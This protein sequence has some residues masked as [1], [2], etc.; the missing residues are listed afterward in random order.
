MPF[1]SG[2]SD[3]RGGTPLFLTTATRDSDGA[4]FLVGVN[5]W[6]TV[7]EGQFVQ[8]CNTHIQFLGVLTA[9]MFPSVGSILRLG[10]GSYFK[11]TSKSKNVGFGMKYPGT[12]VD[13]YS[14]K[15]TRIGQTQMFNEYFPYTATS[16]IYKS[17]V[18]QNWAPTSYAIQRNTVDESNNFDIV[19]YDSFIS[20]LQDTNS[21]IRS[22]TPTGIFYWSGE[23]PPPS[24]WAYQY[25]VASNASGGALSAQAKQDLLDFWGPNT[26]NPNLKN[27]ILPPD[28]T[29]DTSG[30][31]IPNADY[32]SLNQNDNTDFIKT[33]TLISVSDLGILNLYSP[34]FGQMLNFHN[35]LWST[36]FL[37]NWDNQLKKLFGS[38]EEQIIALLAIYADIPLNAST[39]TIILGNIDSGVSSA[40]V[41]K[42]YITLDCG[43]IDIPRVWGNFLDFEPYTT[44]SIYLPFISTVELSANEIVGKNLHLQYKIDVLTGA[45]VAQ[46]K[47]SDEKKEN[48]IL[49][50]SGNCGIQLPWSSANYNQLVSN[51]INALA[52]IGT[53]TLTGGLAPVLNAE[54][55]TAGAGELASMGSGTVKNVFS[56]ASPRF[57]R[58]GSFNTNN[59]VLCDKI[60]H[61]LITRP[62]QSLAQ[63]Y[64][65]FNGFPS[66]VMSKIGAL[67]GFTIIDKINLQGVSATAEEQE[68]IVNILKTGVIIN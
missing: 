35:Y 44:I 17:G 34:T 33:D 57:S 29:L 23:T 21:V 38:P 26:N 32:P 11:C 18:C 58:G 37:Q 65:T 10:N 62:I 13:M 16:G 22:V 61:L 56:G 15:G 51:S 5:F 12:V 6:G 45:C 4:Q 28:F 59:G 43:S 1:S 68:Q 54:S 9:D 20:M 30:E 7:H 49:N 67:K 64:N 42:Q 55:I 3:A 52:T 2:G 50:V 24:S 53:T 8:T 39:S 60:P 47:A 31:N 66:N 63:N 19:D 25:Y 46:L 27:D 36:D 40:T 14:Y 41:A 48:I